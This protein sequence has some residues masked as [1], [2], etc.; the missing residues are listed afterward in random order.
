VWAQFREEDRKN[1]A[2]L[3]NVT[4][5]GAAGN[6][7]FLNQLVE[8]N[9]ANSPAAIQR[10]DGRNVMNVTAR[11]KTDVLSDVMKELRSSISTYELPPGYTIDFGEEFDEL[12]H[13]MANFLTTILFAIILVYI[14]MAALFE[15]LILPLSILMS[16]PIAFV[17]V[18]WGL[19]IM[20]T[21]LDTIGLIGC[22]LMVGVVVRNGI[23][24]ID[25]INLLRQ[26]G[27][28]RHAAVV[29]AGRDRFRPV[30]MTALTTI[31][32]VVPLAI[33]GSGGSTVSFVSLGRAFISGLIS[34]TVLTLVVVPLF[35][36]VF[37]DVQRLFSRALVTILQGWR[38]R[39]DTVT[40]DASEV[41]GNQA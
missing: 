26:E 9:K 36:C 2:N 20:N 8:Y 10:V 11:V 22:I 33:E 28:E 16:V 32:G 31:L 18:Y 30:V 1:R 38:S 14:V 17:G 34:G 19:F 4:L 39:R 12:R 6:S 3:D 40:L 13:N 25:H 37:E 29:Q 15:S 23:V 21:P 7:A 5:F 35:Y 24:I 41:P 27:M